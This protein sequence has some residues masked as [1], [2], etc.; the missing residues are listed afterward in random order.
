M[1]TPVV[2]DYYIT[3]ADIIE[4][5][6]RDQKL[7][8]VESS[9]GSPIANFVENGPSWSETTHESHRIALQKANF[10]HEIDLFANR[11]SATTDF[12]VWL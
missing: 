12:P 9:V 3:F 8:K 2:K 4:A 5:K 6:S 11:P 10:I 1:A 7:S